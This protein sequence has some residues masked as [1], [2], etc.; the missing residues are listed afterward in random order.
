MR[1]GSCPV[2]AQAG[3]ERCASMGPVAL[4]DPVVIRSSSCPKKTAAEVGRGAVQVK[5]Q[6]RERP[7]ASEVER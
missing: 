5:L 3:S 2:R 7:K 6:V 4:G 1:G